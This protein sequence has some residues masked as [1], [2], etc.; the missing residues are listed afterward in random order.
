MSAERRRL[1]RIKAYMSWQVSRHSLIWMRSSFGRLC[2][3]MLEVYV[4]MLVLN[5]V[6]LMVPSLR[7]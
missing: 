2:K 3:A 7:I 6:V 1:I 5:S 4:R